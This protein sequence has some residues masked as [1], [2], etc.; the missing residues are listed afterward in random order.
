MDQDPLT[1][2]MLQ[3]DKLGILPHTKPNAIGLWPNEQECLVWSALQCNA[4][5]LWVEVGSF[6]GGSTILL[7]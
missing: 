3:F 4:D 6:C 1:L 5:Q 2:I 7:G